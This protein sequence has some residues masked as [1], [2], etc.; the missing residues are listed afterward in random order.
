MLLFLLFLFCILQQFSFVPP[1]FFIT[2]VNLFLAFLLYHI[3]LDFY[4]IFLCFYIIEK[5]SA[6][7]DKFLYTNY[8]F[9]SYFSFR[10]LLF[11]FSNCFKL[12]LGV[13]N[14]S[15]IVPSC[16]FN[17]FSDNFSN[18]IM[19]FISFFFCFYFISF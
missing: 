2:F 8:I 16:F 18:I 3:F 9:L 10:L 19:S 4:Y 7:N 12:F 11:S 1:Y 14:S 15:G 6:T 13:G 5:K 17:C